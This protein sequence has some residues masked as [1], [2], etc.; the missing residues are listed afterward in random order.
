MSPDVPP[1][2]PDPEAI[3]RSIRDMYPDSDVVTIEGGSF[4]SLDAERHFPN[5]ATLVWSDDFDQASEL[6]RPGVFRLNLG[7]GRA[8]FD[9]LVG[10]IDDPD[11]A[12]FD[13]FL[14][15]PIYRPALGSA[16]SIRAMRHTATSSCRS[17]QRRTIDSLPSV[18]GTGTV[19]GSDRA[20]QPERANGFGQLCGLGRVPPLQ[21]THPVHGEPLRRL[22]CRHVHLE[23][24]PTRVASRLEPRAVRLPLRC[25]SPRS[26]PPSAG[27]AAC[28]RTGP[29]HGSSRRH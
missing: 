14:P 1:T 18:R 10:T 6:S 19:P 15:H 5:F 22:P 29:W 28:R 3:T 12:A 25:G 21:D 27:R 26:R 11:Y 13:R 24:H 9:R 17:W 4:F 2:G 8:T 20:G 7:V 16:S 23:P